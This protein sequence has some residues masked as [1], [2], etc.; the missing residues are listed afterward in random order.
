MRFVDAFVRVEF[1]FFVY[2]Y[3]LTDSSPLTSGPQ[4]IIIGKSRV[5]VGKCKFWRL[6]RRNAKKFY[7]MRQRRTWRIV[8]R[9]VFPPLPPDTNDGKMA[10]RSNRLRPTWRPLCNTIFRLTSCET[11]NQVTDNII[12]GRS[13][14]RL[15]LWASSAARVR[16]PAYY[17]R[18][19]EL[20]LF[21]GVEQKKEKSYFTR[22]C[23]SSHT[24]AYEIPS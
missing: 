22:P 19:H 4:R 15:S 9:F 20:W 10:V 13:G 21:T 6:R 5:G 1:F 8:P 16:A 24:V 23:G 12:N 2:R 18:S 14:R 11:N 7:R 3:T 17:S